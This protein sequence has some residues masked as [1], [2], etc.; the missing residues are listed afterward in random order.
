MATVTF[1]T[2]G[3]LNGN[4]VENINDVTDCLDKL[5]AGVN[6]VNESQLEATLAAKINR[7]R[8]TPGVV[9]STSFPAWSTSY[10]D[11]TGASAALTLTYPS[12]VLVVASFQ[13]NLRP[14]LSV[15]TTVA[16]EGTLNVD[17]SARSNS[18]IARVVP[19]AGNTN[20]FDDLIVGATQMYAESLA[21][22]AHT[23]KLQARKYASATHPTG[24]SEHSATLAYLV[25][26]DA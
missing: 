8:V 17:G 12:T 20:V 22:G 4:T 13:F 7:L 15:S 19:G 3:S 6:S 5:L 25:I 1:T 18:A 2:R 21:A 26:P 9:R 10:Q 23:L 16:A 24:T 14:L 11:I